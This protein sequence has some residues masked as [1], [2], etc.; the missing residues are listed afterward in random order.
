MAVKNPLEAIAAENF[1]V[2]EKPFRHIVIDNFFRQDFYYNL[3]V[4]FDRKLRKGLFE[5]EEREVFHKFQLSTYD[6]YHC[7]INPEAGYPFE[8]WSMEPET[9]SYRL[10]IYNENTFYGPIYTD[11]INGYPR[12]RVFQ[13]IQ[14]KKRVQ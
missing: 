5:S 7:T 2:K 6:A 14:Y 12:K 13:N 9:Y 4:E 3:C 1:K 11:Q 8:I 10:N